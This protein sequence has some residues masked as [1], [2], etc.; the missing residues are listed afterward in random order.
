MQFHGIQIS[1]G[2]SVSNLTVAS[3]TAFPS[4][5]S[6]AE[7]FYRT[8]SDPRVTGLYLY[9]S[10]TWDRVSSAGSITSPS[11]SSF[12]SAANTGDLFYKDSND[13]LEGLYVYNGSSWM[14]M[15]SPTGGIVVTGDVTGTLTAGASAALTLATITNTGGGSFVKVNID[16]KGRVI[17]TTSVSSSDISTA[18]GYSP[19]SKVG[20]TM[21]G[22]LIVANSST[23]GSITVRGVSE[24]T[25]GSVAIQNS[26]AQRRLEL[27]YVGTGQGATYGIPSGA[28]GVNAGS[29]SLTLSTNDLSRLMIDTS[30]NVL[31]GRTTSSGLGKLQVV[32]NF[33]LSSTGNA[34]LNVRS[35]TAGGLASIELGGNTNAVGSLSFLLRQG[36]S[37]E[38]Y[39]WNRANGPML[40][41]TN[42]TE[43]AQLTATG[44][45]LVGKSSASYSI[46]GSMIAPDGTLSLITSGADASTMIGFYRNSSGTPV[47][48]ISTTSTATTYNTTSDARLKE[49]IV[50][51]PSAGE[52]L[53]QVRV[54]S[55]DW[56][57]KPSEH[58][59]HGFIAQEL[60]EVV[61]S[62]VKA[63]DK[64]DDVWTVWGVD[65]SKLVPLLVKEIQELRERVKALEQK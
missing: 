14:L 23:N 1:E 16:A 9:I 7:L 28:V 6:D 22:N 54:R 15:A 61:P 31:V 59:H 24:A 47:G 51:A 4:A 52:L 56:S 57:S 36:A 60:V 44:T 10:G 8:D 41:G 64:G 35:A 58:V 29:S 48:S 25:S 2:S 20:D 33:D 13:S 65:Y 37:S 32:D 46:Q 53:D 30:G 3:G 63:G 55:Y 12:P 18:L 17:G 26:S 50:D 40:F 39:V 38:A 34:D 45:L 62:A 19:V 27:L 42:G 5:P 11:G 43:R 21:S 49:N